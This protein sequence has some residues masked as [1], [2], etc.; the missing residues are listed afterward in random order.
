MSVEQIFRRINF[1]QLFVD[2]MLE[3]FVSNFQDFV[4]NVRIVDILDV[5]LISVVFY[6]IINWLIQSISRRTLTGFSILLAIYIFARLSGMYLTELLIQALFIV[7]LI[8]LVVIFQS[9][10]RRIVDRIGSWNFFTNNN[11]LSYSNNATNIITEAASGMGENKT[12]ALIVIRGKE[13]W[14]RHIDGGIPLDGKLS[15]PLLY[16]IFNPT[17]PGHDGAVLLEG[18]KIVRFGTHLPL[19]KRLGKNFSGGTRHA[20]ALGIS[21]YCDALVIVVSEESGTISVAQSGTLNKMDSTSELKNTLDNFWNEHYLS[22]NSTLIDSFKKRNL[23]TAIASVVLAGILW[24]A[25]AYQSGTIYRSFSVPIEYRNLQTSNATVQDSLP[26]QAR[27]TLSGPEQAFRT[28]DPSDLV[29]S[30]DLS[31]ENIPSD[32]LLITE[33]NIN[34]SNDFRLYDVNPKSLDISTQKVIQAQI[35]IRVPVSG[36]LSDQLELTSINPVPELVTISIPSGNT[37]PDSIATKSVDLSDIKES[38]K[39][40]KEL[41]LPMGITLFEDTPKEIAISIDVREK[42]N[43]K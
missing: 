19:S 39:V 37:I 29:I 30:F 34:L 43:K 23:R 1:N 14:D 12:G 5:A 6:L 26:I 18:D 15:I 25:F 8:A 42:D 24:F 9:D 13:N 4:L 31:N 11:T 3:S 21:E 28:M 2:D 20:A 35:P 10:I 33:N 36:T 32:E 41:L 40:T 38:S 27:V 22:Q 17:A 16:S 7:I